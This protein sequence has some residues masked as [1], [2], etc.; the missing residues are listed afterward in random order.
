MEEEEDHTSQAS[1]DYFVKM[2]VTVNVTCFFFIDE[3]NKS[4]DRLRLETFF[5]NFSYMEVHET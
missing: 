2:S 1:I 5:Y 3:I 4:R